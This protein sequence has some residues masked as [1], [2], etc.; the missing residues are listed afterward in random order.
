MASVSVILPTYNRRAYLERAIG[1]V[2]RQ[3]FSDWELIIVDDGSSD[4]TADFLRALNNDWSRPQPLRLLTLT[5]GGV[6]RA[7]NQGVQQ[8]KSDWIAFLDSDDEWLPERLA[9]QVPL[10]TNFQMIHAEEIWVRDG[11]RVNQ[12]QK[13]RKSGGRIFSRCVDL[14]C[15]APSATLVRKDLF[16]ALGGFREDFPICEDYDLWLR[17]TAVHAVGFIPEPLIV[18]YGGHD[19]QLSRRFHSMDYFRVKALQ[20]FLSDARLSYIERLHVA[21]TMVKKCEVLLNGYRKHVNLRDSMTVN[22]WHTQA[23]N[24]LTQVHSTHSA[25]DR[26]PRSLANGIL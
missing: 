21:R 5:N 6:S 14:C 15:V 8:A 20:P 22:E 9:R 11:V 1:S 12:A 23:L 17:I 26:R 7:R 3:T 13:H 18:K 2:I 25:A 19:D 24:A 16:L 10:T 4:G